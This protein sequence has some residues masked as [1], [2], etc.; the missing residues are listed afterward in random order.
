M[1]SSDIDN[2]VI[3]K[4]QLGLNYEI[5]QKFVGLKIKENNIFSF[6]FRVPLKEKDEIIEYFSKFKMTE[7]ILVDIGNTGNISCYFRGISPVIKKEDNGVEYYFIS[8]TLQE[9]EKIPPSDQ[10]EMDHT[11]INCGFH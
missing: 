10:E 3:F 5:D 9:I 2:I 6:N 7:P 11:C 8:L 1:T 4:K